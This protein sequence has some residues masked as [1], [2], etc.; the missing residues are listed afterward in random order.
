M[1]KQK[2][3]SIVD[4]DNSKY[5]SENIKFFT[6]KNYKKIPL[7]THKHILKNLITT[8]SVYS[9]MVFINDLTIDQRQVKAV[10]CICISVLD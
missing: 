2:Q 1:I 5:T 10:S 8:K 3:C 7:K 4:F 6:L 9:G